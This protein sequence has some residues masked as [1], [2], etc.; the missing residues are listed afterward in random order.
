MRNCR[1]RQRLKG[2]TT[3]EDMSF[4][5]LSLIFLKKLEKIF[6]Q[7]TSQINLEDAKENKKNIQRTGKAS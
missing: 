6:N 7:K 5:K 1:E 2:E 3:Q 4:K